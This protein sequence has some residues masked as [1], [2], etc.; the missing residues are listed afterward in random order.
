M[1]LRDGCIRDA[2]T[3]ATGEY[4]KVSLE[5]FILCSNF[6]SP[7]FDSIIFRR[8]GDVL[9][10]VHR[11]ERKARTAISVTTDIVPLHNRP[12][13]AMVLLHDKGTPSP[14]GEEVRIGTEAPRKVLRMTCYVRF[15]ILG[16]RTPNTTWGIRLSRK[17]INNT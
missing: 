16:T 10:T 14:I 8:G 6:L 7:H 15:Q 12:G 11:Y 2:R 3:K 1:N 5:T 17:I 9:N 4:R 13:C